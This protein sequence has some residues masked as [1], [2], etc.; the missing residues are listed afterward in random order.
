MKKKNKIN[1]MKGN[2]WTEK[3]DQYLEKLKIEYK[4]IVFKDKK[5]YKKK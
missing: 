2:K 5:I 3:L 1:K 4:N